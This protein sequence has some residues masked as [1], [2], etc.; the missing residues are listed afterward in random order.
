MKS[1][2]PNTYAS[3]GTKYSLTDAVA[4]VAGRVK[5]DNFPNRLQ[6]SIL[7]TVK[8]DKVILRHFHLWKLFS[9]AVRF[10]GAFIKKDGV[11]VLEGRFQLP[12][13]ARVFM[14][15]WLMVII[16]LFCYSLSRVE[17]ISIPV[18]MLALWLGNLFIIGRWGK[19]DIEYV[20]QTITDALQ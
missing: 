20:S 3:Y 19:S 11:V 10:E 15:F 9:G 8:P 16:F 17:F 12:Q 4:H 18:A 2:Y 1:I 13:I 6:G 7:G 14:N 5:K